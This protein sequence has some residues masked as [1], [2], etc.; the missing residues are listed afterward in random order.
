MINAYIDF[1]TSLG[2]SATIPASG[3]FHWGLSYGDPAHGAVVVNN[4]SNQLSAVSMTGGASWGYMSLQ[5]IA[6]LASDT[7]EPNQRYKFT[8]Y[9]DAGFSGGT[10]TLT[11]YRLT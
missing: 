8:N 1:N 10:V 7:Y 3:I 6:T 4:T 5:T 11:V 9:A 2:G